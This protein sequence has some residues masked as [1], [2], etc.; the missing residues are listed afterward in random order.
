VRRLPPAC[1]SLSTSFPDPARLPSFSRGADSN[2]RMIEFKKNKESSK[3]LKFVAQRSKYFNGVNTA[4]AWNCLGSMNDRRH[5]K[6]RADRTFAAF[7]GSTTSKM[8]LSGEE[9]YY[10]VKHYSVILLAVA[11]L[12]VRLEDC[13]VMLKAVERKGDWIVAR[14]SPQS[15][16][17]IAWAF[18]KLGFKPSSFF[19]AVELQSRTLILKMTPQEVSK[20]AWAFAELGIEAPTFFGAVEERSE[21]LVDGGLPKEIADVAWAFAKSREGR[22]NDDAPP[23]ISFFEAVENVGEWMVQEGKGQDIAKTAWAFAAEGM[24]GDVFFKAVER[25]GER[26]VQESKP[27]DAAFTVWA[28]AE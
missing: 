18:A 16:A 3:L 12:G 21:W 15:V 5:A 11:K 10:S 25:E 2:A 4:T 7:L 6:I 26:I 14:G 28:F 19:A 27:K 24:V 20:T 23:P 13:G 22:R 17:D 1:R 8:L 9:E